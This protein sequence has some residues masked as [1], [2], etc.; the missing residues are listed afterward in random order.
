ML[1][2][3]DEVIIMNRQILVLISFILI[4][5][6]SLAYSQN[7]SLYFDGDDDFVQVDGK[8]FHN[9]TSFT[10]SAWIKPEPGGMIISNHIHGS[11]WESIELSTTWFIVNDSNGDWSRQILRFG[12]I[13]DSTWHHIAA[14][15]DGQEMS[16]YL[17]AQRLDTTMAAPSAPW[18]SGGSVAIGARISTAEPPAAAEYMG[19]IDELSIWNKSL[20]QSQITNIMNDTIPSLYY[21]SLDSGLIA[22]WRFDESEGDT[23]FD[24]TANQYSGYITGATRTDTGFPLS[25]KEARNSKSPPEKYELKQNYPN[26]FNPSTVIGWQLAVASEVE[27]SVYNL[28]GQK[29]ATLVSEQQNAGNHQVEWNAHNMPTGV[30][31][32]V[33]NAGEFYQVRKMVLLK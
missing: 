28:L 24:L 27:L 15:W 7:R 33:I 3:N 12:N 18:N 19:Y 30:Y 5:T 9:L 10:I 8:I 32:Y 29:L 22:Y 20:V 2:H 11:T 1:N 31:Y 26:P 25:L 14:V 16:I 6:N 23:T 21:N 17:D 4:C 13:N